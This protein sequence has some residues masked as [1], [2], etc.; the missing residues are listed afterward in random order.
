MSTSSK[1]VPF[2]ML[3]I[4]L[5]YSNNTRKVLFL[6]SNLSFNE[7]WHIGNISYY[8]FF[9]ISTLIDIEFTKL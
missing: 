6:I 9:F 2:Y 1:Y 8:S 7:F 3:L 5:I 4:Y